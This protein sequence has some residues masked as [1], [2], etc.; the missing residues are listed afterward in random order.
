[1]HC[2]SIGGEFYTAVGYFETQPT[3]ASLTNELSCSLATIHPECEKKI[4]S[5][6]LET[7]LL[8]LPVGE[9]PFTTQAVKCKRMK[10]LTTGM[11]LG[12][13]KS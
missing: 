13:E 12:G 1:M 6:P 7:P 11:E 2:A 8:H 4:T 9:P 5:S 10:S 3:F